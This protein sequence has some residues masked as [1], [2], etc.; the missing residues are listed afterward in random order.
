MSS[1]AAAAVD[2]TRLKLDE[3]QD[4]LAQIHEGAGESDPCEPW[5]EMQTEAAAMPSSYFALHLGYSL[6]AIALLATGLLI[7]LP[8]WRGYFIGGYG[9][10]LATIHEWVGVAML[11][12]P[13]FSLLRRPAATRLALRIRSYKREHL[14][15]HAVNL[16][17]TVLSG[18]VFIVTGFIMWFQGSLPDSIVDVSIELHVIFTYAL[19]VVIPIHL[20]TSFRRSVTAVVRWTRALTGTA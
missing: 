4:D 14:R 7:Q 12:L 11:V 15:L 2:T 5:D 19:L 17:F 20:I 16:W 8:D 13:L 3:E 10:Q 18:V 1:A 6:V 9:R